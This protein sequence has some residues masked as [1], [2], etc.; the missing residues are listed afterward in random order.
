M[1]KLIAIVLSLVLTM[2]L[3]ACTKTEPASNSGNSG[4]SIQQPS[5]NENLQQDVSQN[6]DEGAA[7]EDHNNTDVASDALS[8]APTGVA[9]MLPQNFHMKAPS[10]D[11][12]KIGNDFMNGSVCPDFY[13]YVGHDQYEIYYW[14]NDNF[15]DANAT[16]GLESL[17]DMTADCTKDSRKTGETKE[18]CGVSCAEYADD[19]TGTTYYLYEDS[20]LLFE[21]W[22]DGASKA[23]YA[24]TEWDETITEF[25]CEP[26]M[27]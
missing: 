1:K 11:L 13:R 17:L 10:L 27:K 4:S 3:V 9:A 7:Q 2:S 19:I 8:D 24:A 26:P 16:M 22:Y 21:V 18:I 14:D 23:A 12:Y 25:P 6:S 15:V 20:G 5:Q